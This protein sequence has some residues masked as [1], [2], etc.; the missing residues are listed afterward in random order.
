LYEKYSAEK[1]IKLCRGL[2]LEVIPKLSEAFDCILIDGDHNWFTVFNELQEIE[3]RKLLKDG[4]TIFFHD[5]GWPYGRRDLYYQPETIPNEFR[6]PYARQGIVNGKSELSATS[7][8]NGAFCNATKEGG[9]RNGVLTAIEDFR[10]QATNEYVWFRFVDECGLGVLVKKR[11]VKSQWQLAKWRFKCAI[12]NIFGVTKNTVKYG[13]P[14][15]YEG[16][17]RRF[18]RPKPI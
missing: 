1:R 10:K 18:R 8:Q 4:G 3:K 2:S 14:N 12:W 11:G 6:H 16:I 5:I 17:R 9:E 13:S 15:L 7:G